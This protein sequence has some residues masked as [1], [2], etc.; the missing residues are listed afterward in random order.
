MIVADGDKDLTTKCKLTSADAFSMINPLH[1]MIDQELKKHQEEVN[2]QIINHCSDE[3][4][5]GLYGDMTQIESLKKSFYD[6]AR[7]LPRSKLVACA[8]KTVLWFCQ[9]PLFN[10]LKLESDSATPNGL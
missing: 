9:S 4:R 5:C 2:S 3:C 8:E 6:K 1:A 10:S 7:T